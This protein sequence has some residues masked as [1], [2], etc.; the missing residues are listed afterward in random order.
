M[1]FANSTNLDSARLERLC[2]R[3]TWPYRHDKL[4]VRVRYSRGADFS[5]TCYYSHARLFINLGRRNKYPYLLGTNIARSRSN[6]THWWRETY[7]LTIADAYQLALFVFLHE[8]YHYLVKAA[9]RCPRRK[10]AMC[11]RFATRVIKAFQVKDKESIKHMAH[12]H[13]GAFLLDS[14]KDGERG[15]TGTTFD[16]H[17][18]VVAKT[19]GKVIL[20]GGLTPEN[21]VEA[22]K[23]VQ[24]YGVDV[25]GG[26]EK[27]KGIKD[28]A[29]MK[30]FITEVRRASRP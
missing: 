5:G 15:G 10:E 25:A 8:L 14:Y 21:V 20:A 11:D 18:A 30:K 29:K 2:V 27:G 3:H 16:W 17:L 24:P 1:D 7:R 23:L 6:R 28:H 13:V 12:Y 22:V 19:F 9:G 26:V 4:T